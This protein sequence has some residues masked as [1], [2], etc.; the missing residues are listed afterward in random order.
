QTDAAQNPKAVGVPNSASNVET[1]TNKA[2]TAMSRKSSSKGEGNSNS[3]SSALSKL[4]H[5]LTFLKERRSQIATELQNLDKGRTSQPVP[6]PEQGRGSEHRHSG[7]NMDKNQESKRQSSE[8]NQELEKNESRQ[9]PNG[10]LAQNV[11]KG[12]K[13]GL[14]RGKFESI[15]RGKSESRERGKHESTDKGHPTFASRTF[16][17]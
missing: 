5:R 11:D 1:A 6:N 8:K 9:N 12:K 13:S 17:R 2:G 14:E 10:Q 7:E 15:E 3:T 4:T 16:S